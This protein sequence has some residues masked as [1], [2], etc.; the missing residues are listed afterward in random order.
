MST[1]KVSNINNVAASGG[2]LS[3][4]ANGAVSGGLPSPNRN[5]LYNGAMQVHQRGTSTTGI[6]TDGFYTADRW[7]ATFATLGTWTQTVESDAPTGS[8]L[9]KSLKML[10]TTA[11]A[12]PAAGDLLI[13][14]QP[15]EGQDVQRVA[16]GTA[17]AQQLTLS[18][19]VKANVTGTYAC[20]LLDGD[21]SR[22]VS[23]TYSVSASATWEKKTI[24][25][26]ADTTGAFDNDNGGSLTVS[27]WLGAGTT[28]TSGTLAT[29]W[30]SLTSA[31]RA[32]GQTNLAAATNN[33]WQITGVQLEVGPVATPFEFKSYGQELRECQRYYFRATVNAGSRAFANGHN[34]STT[35]GY[36]VQHFPVPMRSNPS[37]LETT[38]TASDYHITHANTNTA[39][40]AVPSISATTETA[41]ALLGTVSSGLTTGQGNALRSNTASAY[42]GWSAEL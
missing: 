10:C 4:D 27:W 23:A 7:K 6:T 26:P 41:G 12:A 17:S 34:V 39:L 5:L 29:T 8:G 40:S 33:Y 1:L 16:K 15:L 25:F 37:A 9:R 35:Q 24:T 20:E 28:F 31:N 2:G 38:G 21:N 22:G 14:N 11:D 3:I 13:I 30:A 19:W 32:V 42:L 18:F 36:A